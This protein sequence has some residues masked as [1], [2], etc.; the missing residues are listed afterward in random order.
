MEGSDLPNARFDRAFMF[1]AVL[2]DSKLRGATMRQVTLTGAA[3][4]GAD[5]SGADLSGS[6]LNGAHLQDARLRSARLDDTRFINAVL[7]RTDFTDAV[8][9]PIHLQEMLARARGVTD[10]TRGARTVEPD[11]VRP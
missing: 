11:T 3:L 9:M 10:V 7:E 1:R 4:E 5:F 8:N 2:I 6:L